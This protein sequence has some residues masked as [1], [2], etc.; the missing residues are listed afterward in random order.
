MDGHP[1]YSSA[2]QDDKPCTRTDWSCEQY[3]NCYHVYL[4]FHETSQL[5]TGMIMEKK[6]PFQD[7]VAYKYLEERK[8]F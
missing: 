7:F 5:H 8:R 2:Y 4:S 3:S 6:F 1:V